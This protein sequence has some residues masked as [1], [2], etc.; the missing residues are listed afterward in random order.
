[1]FKNLS[2]LQKGI[3]LAFATAL[4]SGGANFINKLSMSAVAKGPYQYT[5]LKN[6]IVALVLTV[7][8]LIG[9]TY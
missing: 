8:I 2:T 1:M 7:I 4:I 9:A 6:L 5:T 3:Y